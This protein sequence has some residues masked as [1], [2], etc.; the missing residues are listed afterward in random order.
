MGRHS[1]RDVGVATMIV[2]L[3]LL[4]TA[5]PGGAQEAPP[6]LQPQGGLTAG[7]PISGDK[8]P[9]SRLARS[10]PALLARTDAASVR[11]MIKLDY[12]SVAT[13]EGGVE[14]I[15]A[16]SPAVT[17][18]ALTRRSSAERRYG[19]YIDGKVSSFVTALGRAVPQ[20]KVGAR[21]DVVYGGVAA[22]VPANKVKDI[23]A[24]PGVVAV[25]KNALNHPLT[26]SSPD[27]IGAPTLYKQLGGANNAGK[28]VI[29]GDLDTGLWPEHPS[30][31]DHGNLGAPPAP[32]GGGTRECN[33]GD[34]PLTPQTDVFPCQDK[35]I[36][37]AHF[38]DDYDAAIGDDPF[39]GTARDFEGHGTHTSSTTAGG[40]VDDVHVLGIPRGDIHGIAPGAWIMEY[41]VCGPQGCLNSD[42]TRAVEQA[43]LDGVDVI[44]F[45]I[46]GGTQPFNDPVELAFLDAYAA[47][48]FVST[49]AGNDGPTAGTA[50]H[51]SPWTT[52]VAASSQL[53]E[54]GSDLK[55]TAGNGDTLTVH[56]A[57]L[58]H[59]VP[60]ATPVV[61]ASE[62]PGYGDQFC[63][64][65]PPPGLFAGKVVA[66]QRGGNIARVL[67][68]FNVLA[69][70][71]AG[72]VIYNPTLAD[73]ETD[74]H[75]LPAIHL[76][77]GS[78]FLTFLHAHTG[79]TGSWADGKK[80]N[81]QGDVM[82]SFSSRGPAGAFI[83]PDITAPGVQIL[84]GNTP[85]P[86]D[87][88]DGAGPPGELFQAIAG[89]S[90]AA[91]HVAGSGVL[92]AA[93][94]PEWTPGQIRS[95]LMTSAV[96]DVVEQ[97]RTTPANPFD[98]GSGRID[99]TKAGAVPLTFDETADRFF[100]LGADPVNAVNLN[101][102]SVNAPVMPG[103]V[104]TTRTAKN[105]SG[106][107]QQFTVSIDQPAIGT[108]SV[109]PRR[110]T[111][112]VGQ[113]I[114]LNITIQAPVPGDQQFGTI[115]LNGGRNVPALHL[116]VAFVP[117][118]SDVS[119]VQSCS[120]ASIQQRA[121]SACTVAATNN[122]F[123][124][125]TVDISTEVGRGL[126]VAGTD[127][128]QQ[129]G[130]RT[131]RLP[132]V[133][134]AGR[135]PGVPSVDPGSLFGYLPLDQFGVTPQAIG[136]EQII[137][138][139]TPVFDYAGQSWDRIGVTSDGY[140]VVGG[141]DAQDVNC[142]SIPDGPDPA[143]PNNVLAPLWTDLDGTNSDGILADVLTDGTNSWIVIE[144]R[145]NLFG[146][147]D[148]QT[149][150]V[151]IGIDGTEDITY[152]YNPDKLPS[153][154]GMDFLVG[155]ENIL[156]AGDMEAVVPTGDLR[157]TSTD[158]VPGDTASYIVFARGRDQG[159]WPVTSSMTADGVSGTTVVTSNVAVTRRR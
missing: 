32:P 99:L 74:N 123:S 86:G 138:F 135:Q 55:L 113:S 122:T 116:P 36:G 125:T 100:A 98:M 155:A 93:L 31:A 58:T 50:N 8:A 37:G 104:T 27:F 29:F 129:T 156:G 48:V 102:P 12:D 57:T 21:V 106:R 60:T 66:C 2:A 115:H 110:F 150:E 65:A 69:G 62:V 154:P 87:P 76:Y 142:C 131:A 46:S 11:V 136:D 79:V 44:N 137:N 117:K 151:W 107:R 124:D 97:D 51:L 84:A 33:F 10:D 101:I 119:L 59:G 80:Q 47:G 89:T 120:P 141:G 88:A 96:T 41:K 145:L 68:G 25:Q 72:L 3:L 6:P 126:R 49:S 56:G 63:G 143:R 158:G 91:P 14:G 147:D 26:D 139:D 152:A 18:H 132:D 16:T 23:A 85:W 118:Q 108:I 71:G 159:T 17:G 54:F 109:Q 140:L 128:G 40:Q 35:L 112:G 111:L 130:P 146:T 90:M 24:M 82:T 20:A 43:I 133:H 103:E 19:T 1:V 30:F 61:L 73:A 148:L 64:T 67:K 22:V 34:N 78:Q 92:L 4:A 39:A 77:D 127:G 28:G 52:S 105:I 15:P 153:D 121:T 53:R 7:Q 81:L 157:V 114:T 95:A 149:F 75:F 38:T 13:Y 144:S 42:S 70:G 83:K 45:S 9:S 134:L 5:A 94:H